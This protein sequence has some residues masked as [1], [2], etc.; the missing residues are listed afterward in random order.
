MDPNGRTALVSGGTSGLG[1]ATATLLASRGANVAV[2]GV[3]AVADIAAEIGPDVLAIE[4]DITDPRAVSSAVE[5][6]V[7]RF[8]RLDINVNT[9]GIMTPVTL[10]DEHDRPNDLAALRQ[11]IEV[12]L[13]GTYGVVARCVSTM[14]RNPIE[15]GERGVVINTASIAAIEGTPGQAAY[16]T[17]KAGLIALALPIAR[18][19][20]GRGI[21]VNTITP[22]GFDTPMN[23]WIPPDFIEA[24]SAQIPNPQRLGRSGEYAAMALALIEN[25]YAN[26]TSVR[27]DGAYRMT[28]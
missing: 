5:H 15:A 1:L 12:N 20:A 9:A 23:A 6:V 7:D 2:L 17:T 25:T 4:A 18:E 27:L 24:V 8:G 22:G 26:A 10:L 3:G 19:F 16:A 14:L 21:R 13:I 11:M 28:A